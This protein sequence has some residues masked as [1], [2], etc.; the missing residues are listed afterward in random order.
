MDDNVIIATAVDDIVN[1]THLRVLAGWVD[2]LISGLLVVL[3]ALAFDRGV[4]DK[5]INRGFALGQGLLVLVTIGSASYTVYLVDL[6][7]C[8]VFAL[9]YF[10]L[11]KLYAL[12]DVN[13]SRGMPAFT[14]IG[15]DPRVVDRVVTFGFDAS[16]IARRDVVRAKTGLERRFGVSRIFHIDNA[17]GVANLLGDTCAGLEFFIVFAGGAELP[18]AAGAGTAGALFGESA[19]GTPLSGLC[20]VSELGAAQAGDGGAIQRQVGHALMR[21]ADRLI[22]PQ[23][24]PAG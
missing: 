7:A 18:A 22:N 10:V 17:F 16:G 8:I 11:A 5:S 12:I 23:P 15:F 14:D 3:L 20:D 2:A 24:D 1:D 21:V 4:Q 19:V 13:A 9:A 6:S